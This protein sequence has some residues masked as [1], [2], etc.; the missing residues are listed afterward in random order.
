MLR[1][2]WRTRN[3]KSIEL[4]ERRPRIAGQTRGGAVAAQHAAGDAVADAFVLDAVRKAFVEFF[5][6]AETKTDDERQQ[7]RQLCR[8]TEW[9]SRRRRTW[10]R[11]SPRPSTSSGRSA[12]SFSASNAP[13]DR[14]ATNMWSTSLRKRS[15]ASHTLRYQSRQPV[16][17][18]SSSSPQCP[19]S[20]MR[21][22]RK[23]GPVQA[24]RDEAHFGR[25]TGKTVDQQYPGSASGHVVISRLDHQ[26]G[27]R[28]GMAL[29]CPRRRMNT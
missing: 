3:D 28:F 5:L 19:A 29:F 21:V 26:T 12:A 13:I 10:F 24:F 4:R 9:S 8:A 16:L 23:T 18:R 27:R 11:T 25:R 6:V 7:K 20:C 15:A 17:S 22:H 14:P 2:C 1:N